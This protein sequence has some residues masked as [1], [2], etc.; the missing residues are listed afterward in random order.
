M[1]LL[2]QPGSHP[3]HGNKLCVLEPWQCMAVLHACRDSVSLALVSLHKQRPKQLL[4]LLQPQQGQTRQP[5]R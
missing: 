4:A 1:Q 3:P 2:L 5:H